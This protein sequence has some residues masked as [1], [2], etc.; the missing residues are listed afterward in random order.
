[1]V[2]TKGRTGLVGHETFDSPVFNT[3]NIPQLY[4]MDYFAA[5]VQRSSDEGHQM[6][7]F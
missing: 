5:F 2:K 1:M 7:T 4:E 6:G 3:L